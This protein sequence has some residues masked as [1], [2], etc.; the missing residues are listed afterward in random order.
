MAPP[1]HAQTHT[2]TIQRNAQALDALQPGTP[3]FERLIERLL[4]SLAGSAR[5][6]VKG[7]MG[8]VAATFLEKIRCADLRCLHASAPCMHLR[9]TRAL[10]TSM[11]LA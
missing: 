5:G 2:C 3:D 9:A 10:G 6:P 8:T 7:G 1:S 11:G 4:L